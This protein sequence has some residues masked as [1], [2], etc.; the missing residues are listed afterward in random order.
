MSFEDAIYHFWDGQVSS[1]RLLTVILSIAAG[2]NMSQYTWDWAPDF[3]LSDAKDLCRRLKL[4]YTG[5]LETDV[6]RAQQGEPPLHFIDHFLWVDIYR[7][8]HEIEYIP[9]VSKGLQQIGSNDMVERIL[10]RIENGFIDAPLELGWACPREQS[11][12]YASEEWQN[13]AKAHRYKDGYQCYRCRRRNVPLHV[14]HTGPIISAYHHN[15]VLN[16]AWWKLETTCQDCHIDFHSRTVRAL[17]YSGYDF[18]SPERIQRKRVW[19]KQ[20]WR[21]YHKDDSCAWCKNNPEGDDEEVH[22]FDGA[23][24]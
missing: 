22:F 2:D 4:P 5:V 1:T 16:F 19:M 18:A 20:V 6:E 9:P 24:Q 13:C 12:F 3:H 23:D 21:K 10:S 8:H 17:H 11:F 7:Y 14:H 15:F